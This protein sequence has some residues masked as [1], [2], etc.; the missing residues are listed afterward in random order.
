MNNCELRYWSR[1]RIGAVMRF[2]CILS[3]MFLVHFA[4][5]ATAFNRAPE[6]RTNWMVLEASKDIPEFPGF[7]FAAK[8]E[9]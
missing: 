1:T 3:I 2:G 9:I 7:I 4:G 6:Q 8:P 5:A